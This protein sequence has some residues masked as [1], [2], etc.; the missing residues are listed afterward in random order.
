M[1]RGN[2]KMRLFWNDRDYLRLLGIVGGVLQDYDV[3]C[4]TYCLMPNHYHLI[5]RTRQANLSEAVRQLNG[6]FAQWWNKRHRH[7]GHVFQGRFK[8]Q[9]VEDNQYLL[10]LCR[11]VLLNPVRARRCATPQE[12]RWSSY[13]A[14][15]SG[16]AEPSWVDVESLLKRFEMTDIS[17]TRGR[18]IAFVLDACDDEMAA[19]VRGDARIIGSEAYAARFEKQ[20]LAASPEVPAK[21][22]RVGSPSLAT[23]LAASLESAEGLD[24]AIA[25]AHHHYDYSI[26]DIARCTRLS[27]AVV[28]RLLRRQAGVHHVALD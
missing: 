20:A 21:E 23:I 15:I 2:N 13:P 3:E 27:S 4:W 26:A 8:A 5:W 12:W 18:L 16:V 24:A 11:Y 14:L 6:T 17:R 28:A 7:V 25:R 1:A 19:F 22:R 10:R 9:I